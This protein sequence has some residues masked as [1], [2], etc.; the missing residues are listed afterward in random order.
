MMKKK[1]EEEAKDTSTI[2]LRIGHGAAICSG[3]T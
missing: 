2:S 3:H 1:G